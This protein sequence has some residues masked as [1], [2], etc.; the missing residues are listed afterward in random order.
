MAGPRA[1]KGHRR[2]GA[3]R[4]GGAT[5]KQPPGC[6]WPK[7]MIRTA[8]CGV[9][10]SGK[11]ILRAPSAKESAMSE[12]VVVGSINVDFVARVARLPRPGETVA[13]GAFER[14]FGG[15]GANQAV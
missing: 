14:H 12:L 1:S 10:A 11:G 15:K 4:R 3:E 7:A 5:S 8:G 2:R 13:G 9:R 6:R